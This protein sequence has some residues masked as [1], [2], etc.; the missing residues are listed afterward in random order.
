MRMGTIDVSGGVSGSASVALSGTELPGDGIVVSP[1]AA[2]FGSVAVNSTSTRQTFTIPNLG[3]S[4]T[5]TL[6]TS[7]GGNDPAH[8]M[9]TNDACTGTQLQAG[10]QCTFDIVFTPT[11][12]GAKAAHVQAV[13]TPGGTTVAGLD[14]TGFDAFAQR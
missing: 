4:P 9:I 5:G 8:F 3:G 14:G 11:T 12:S 2:S 1:T 13:A 10:A 7:L 6:S